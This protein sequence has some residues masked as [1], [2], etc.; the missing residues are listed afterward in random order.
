[1]AVCVG[2]SW[3][4]QNHLYCILPLSSIHL[5]YLSYVYSH[6]YPSISGCRAHHQVISCVPVHWGELRV[7]QRLSWHF[8]SLDFNR[9][10][11]SP[12]STWRHTTREVQVII[13]CCCWCCCCCCCCWYTASS[14]SRRGPTWLQLPTVMS[15]H[16]VVWGGFGG[17][18][19]KPR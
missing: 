2:G 12:G 3:S 17:R 6:L 16:G 1:M 9:V 15:L 8:L 13:C 18:L 11:S 19:D 10:G 14:Q 4:V 5:K 7:H